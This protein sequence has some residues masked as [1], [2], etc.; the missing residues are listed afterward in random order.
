MKNK[1]QIKIWFKQYVRSNTFGSDNATETRCCTC[2][3]S[4]RMEISVL[5]KGRDK[6]NNNIHKEN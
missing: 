3:P 1:N 4:N 5:F 2:S 6:S